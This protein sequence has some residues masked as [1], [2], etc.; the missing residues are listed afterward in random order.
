L[1]VVSDDL[2]SVASGGVIHGVIEI[3][4]ADNVCPYMI[5]SQMPLPTQKVA[6]APL[7]NTCSSSAPDMLQR[8]ANNPPSYPTTP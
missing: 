7:N 6:N 2:A 1:P 4:T 3:N 8:G 5:G